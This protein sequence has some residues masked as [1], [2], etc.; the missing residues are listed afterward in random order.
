MKYRERGK[1]NNKNETIDTFD[2]WFLVHPVRPVSMDG[3]LEK[4]SFASKLTR[5]D[6]YTL[7][8]LRYDN[9]GV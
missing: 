3:Y 5:P 4:F 7:S 8:Y 6:T 1:E 9:G 2:W